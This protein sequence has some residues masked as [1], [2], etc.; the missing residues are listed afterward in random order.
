M[1]PTAKKHLLKYA[2]YS[3]FFGASFLF[4]LYLTFPYRALTDMAVGEARKAG[5]GLSIG[6]VGPS[7]LFWVKA[8][9]IALIMPK[10]EG[11]PEPQAIPIE[12][13]KVRPTLLP[14]GLAYQAR[15]FS[16]SID[17]QVGLLGKQHRLVVKVKE[18]DLGK[19]NAKAALGLDLGGKLD[20][21]IDV[22]LDPDGTKITG[23]VGLN[24]EGFAINGGTVAQYDLPKVDI[25][26]LDLTLK[27]DGGKASVDFFKA[28]GADVDANLE[29]EI[30]LA[31]KALLSNLKLKLKFKPS[32]DFLKR[33][34]FIQTGLNFAMSKDAKG[35]Y[36][37][38]INR[39]L[40]NPGFVPQR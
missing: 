2:G 13:I 5:I 21:D 20:T 34:S 28:Q 11:G 32:D 19:A 1:S 7:W 26:H 35:F 10:Q 23:K 33:N 16:G 18:L 27:I 8:K 12:E 3:A 40:G 14:P 15:L 4:M 37:V 36:T 39:A 30:A 31:P 17:G 24:A 29:G 22:V 38:N 6:S 9:N 25:G